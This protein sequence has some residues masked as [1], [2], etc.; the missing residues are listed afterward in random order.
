M[1]RS[2]GGADWTFCS[3]GAA[4]RRLDQEP[5]LGVPPH[6]SVQVQ[7]RVEHRRQPSRRRLVVL[8]QRGNE[9]VA[10]AFHQPP[11]HLPQLR[12][13]GVHAIQLAERL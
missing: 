7:Q 8:R 5:R 9:T 2:A 10:A 1:A 11:D 12:T 4:S 13:L 6:L 3:P